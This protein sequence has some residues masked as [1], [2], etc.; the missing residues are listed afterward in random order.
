MSTLIQFPVKG[1]DHLIE[2]SLFAFTAAYKLKTF[3]QVRSINIQLN[4]GEHVGILE[5]TMKGREQTGNYFEVVIDDIRPGP[6]VGLSP[7]CNVIYLRVCCR[8]Q[9]GLFT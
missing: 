6:E 3:T 8:L 5:V 1:P 9:L 2:L 4:K 7:N